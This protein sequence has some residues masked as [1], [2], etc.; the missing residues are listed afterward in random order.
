MC[1]VGRVD[2]IVEIWRYVFEW[3]VVDVGDMFCKNYIGLS[4]Y[5]EIDG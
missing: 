4:I 2:N 5:V 1:V 3:V